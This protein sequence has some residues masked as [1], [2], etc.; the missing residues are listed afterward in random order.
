MIFIRGILYWVVVPNI[1]PLQAINFYFLIFWAKKNGFQHRQPTNP[2][3]NK[4]T[5]VKAIVIN[6]SR[7]LLP[8]AAFNIVLKKFIKNVT[9]HL[10]PASSLPLPQPVPRFKTLAVKIVGCQQFLSLQFLVIWH[11]HDKFGCS[12]AFALLGCCFYRLLLTNI[13]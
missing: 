6:D 8:H 4:L 11:I 7:H 1:N 13:F 10:A 9:P 12:Q 3:T 2:P 5:K